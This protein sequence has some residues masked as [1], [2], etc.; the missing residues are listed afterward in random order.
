M[1]R[2]KT[3]PEAAPDAFTVAVRL[4]GQRPH[5]EHELTA[6][7]ARRGCPPEAIADALARA[8]QLGY[9]DDAAFA[10]ALVRRRGRSRGPHLITAELASRGVDRDVVREAIAAL[11]REDQ[12]ASARRQA[13]SLSAVNIRKAAGRLQ[14]LGFSTDVI[15]EALSLDD[16]L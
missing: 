16:E 9:L 14:R 10:N 2:P 6:K 5:S 12:V 7:L 8:R 4:L 15:R 11:T 3:D 13:R 1:W